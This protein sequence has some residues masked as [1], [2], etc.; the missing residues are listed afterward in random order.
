V[1][2]EKDRACELM[3]RSCLQGNTTKAA[4]V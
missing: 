4:K 3:H 1:F 2:Q